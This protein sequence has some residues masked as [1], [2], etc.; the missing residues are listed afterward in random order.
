MTRVFDASAVL[1]ALFNEPGADRVVEL[2]TGAENLP[3][4]SA[5]KS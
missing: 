1:A 5:P 4:K 3:S 2:W